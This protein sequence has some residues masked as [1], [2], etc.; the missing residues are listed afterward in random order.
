ME[1]KND[2]SSPLRGEGKVF[3]DSKETNSLSAAPEAAE[4][5]GIG[6]FESVMEFRVRFSET[7]KM[8]VVHHRNYFSWFE[9]GRGEQLRTTGFSY[10]DLEDA[11]FGFAIIHAECDYK[12]PALYDDILTLRTRVV[13]MTRVKVEH[14]YRLFRGVELLAVGRTVLACLNANGRVVAIPKEIFG[15]GARNFPNR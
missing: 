10:R 11:G 15:R 12:K 3:P 8:G 14:E 5:N 6:D 1:E 4:Q 7:D 9:M 2:H 13:H